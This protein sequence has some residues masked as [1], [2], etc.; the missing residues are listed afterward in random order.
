M[1]LAGGDLV[2][3]SPLQE[4]DPVVEHFIDE[5]IRF[6]NSTGPHISP[7]V[8]QM[9]GLA[10]SRE[11]ITQCGFHQGQHFEGYLAVGIYPEAKIFEAFLLNDGESLSAPRHS[12][13][14][15]FA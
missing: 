14:P 9:L 12:S 15:V 13:V 11:G 8:A 1:L 2:V 4:L 10:D 7:H 3:V 5:T 6:R